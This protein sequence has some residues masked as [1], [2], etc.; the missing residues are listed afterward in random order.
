MIK[1]DL[2]GSWKMKRV[3]DG[4][5]IPGNVPGS[6]FNDLLNA[7]RIP[8]PFYRDN[9]DEARIIASYDYEYEREFNIGPELL[10][11]DKLFLRCDG[12]DTLTEI[13][14]NGGIIAKTDNMHRIYEFE[15]KE[16]LHGDLNKIN[17]I[18]YSPLEL[19][20]RKQRERPLL[21]GTGSIPGNAYI[22]KAHCMFGWDWGPQIPDCGIWRDIS[23]I[24][25]N[26][27]RL[28]DIYVVQSHEAGKVILDIRARAE[29]WDTAV[30]SLEA[31]I[32]APDGTV[33][34][35]L[36]EVTGFENHMSV[37]INSPQL[38]WPNSFGKQP[39]YK[40]EVRLK[41]GGELLDTANLNIGL[42]KL[43]VKREKDQWGETFEFEINGYSIFAMGAD[44]IPDDNLLSRCSRERTERLIKD[45]VE[46]NFN[47]IR[48]WGGGVYPEDYFYDLCDSYGLLVWQDFMFAC[49]VYEMTPEFAGNIRHEARD[50]VKRLRHHA[51]LGLWCGN[52][53]MEWGWND[54]NFEKT[55]RLRADYI[56]QFEVLLPEVAA[57]VDP[58]TLYWPSSPSSGG[59]FDR[60]NDDNMGDVHYW[61][62]WHSL[63]PFTEYRKHYFR[64]CSEFGFQSFPCLKTVESFTLPEDRNV[65]SRI[66]E[67][68]QKNGAANGRIL[69]YL[70]DNFKYPRDFDS[71]LYTSQILQAEAIRYGVEHW[72]RNRGRCMGAIYWQLNDCWPVASWSSIDS[73]GRWKA[74]HYYAKRFFSPILLSACEEGSGVEL[75]VTN[76]TMSGVSG[77]ISWKLR[78]NA[79]NILSEG[80]EKAVVAPLSSALCAGMDFPGI[81]SHKDHRRKSY[82]EYVL[83]ID[84]INVSEGTVLFVR[85]KH[86]E[87]LDPGLS[88]EVVDSGDEF[89]IEVRSKAFAKYVELDLKDADCVFGNNYFDLSAGE[90]KRVR[91]EKSRISRSM[92]ADE[93][94]RSLKVRSIFD[95]A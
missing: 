41:K 92:S 25:F 49:S 77:E 40:V 13:R 54:W 44:Y 87:F 9:E 29:N 50:N 7:G 34:P 26:T 95:I 4:D 56:K 64:F 61:E 37:G 53:E 10:E 52:N 30:L 93:L 8:D 65:F 75:H 73:L 47:C 79:S 76:E 16:Y 20:E 71:L 55:P 27:A 81:L 82:M 88:F 72:R 66:M 15:I 39:L 70:S 24:G 6:V 60:P 67:K 63:K 18:I 36:A 5:W 38:W 32:T 21:H 2:G 46:A 68:H 1:L 28:D 42:R 59:S 23:I 83:S 48:V 17:I 51:S 80:R 12:L 22:R 19:M 89:V 78:D 74:L 85:P 31:L 94:K 90:R 14:I 35:A 86:F 91:L 45:C 43:R 11:Y 3:G 57:E 69:F 62:V 33:F 58:N 84:G